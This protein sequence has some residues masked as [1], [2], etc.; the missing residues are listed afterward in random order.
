[1]YGQQ[2]VPF[3]AEER[4]ADPLD[5]FLDLALEG[6]EA[7]VASIEQ[8]YEDRTFVTVTVDADPGRDFGARGL[9]GHRFFFLP[10][11]VEP[12]GDGREP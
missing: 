10:D 5:T 12:L 11:E 8:D 9:P 4:G 3:N 6:E 7:T 1:M 2:A